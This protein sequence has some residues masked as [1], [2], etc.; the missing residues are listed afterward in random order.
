[1]LLGKFHLHLFLGIALARL[2]DI[3]YH[4][5]IFLFYLNENIQRGLNLNMRT[6]ELT[7]LLNGEYMGYLF[8]QS[9]C[10]LYKIT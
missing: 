5:G 3:S 6:T 7:K 2:Y 9:L 1:L 4:P 10:L 8:V